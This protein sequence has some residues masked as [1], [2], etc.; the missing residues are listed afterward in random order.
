MPKR[1]RRK[2]EEKGG[3]E[4][5]RRKGEDKRGLISLTSTSSMNLVELH[6]I[7]QA[8]CGCLLPL[9]TPHAVRL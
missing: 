8:A 2:E 5:G 7:G 6:S 4:K 1:K 3:R 9:W